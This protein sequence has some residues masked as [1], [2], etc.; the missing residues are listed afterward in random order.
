MK[1]F[2]NIDCIKRTIQTQMT[3]LKQKYNID[4][5]CNVHLSSKRVCVKIKNLPLL[6]ATNEFIVEE[7]KKFQDKLRILD[8]SYTVIFMENNTD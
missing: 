2:E 1:D 3:I 8:P 5:K 7:K 6:Y 4:I